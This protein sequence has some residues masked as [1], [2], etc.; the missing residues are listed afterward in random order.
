MP[1]VAVVGHTEWLTFARVARLP[2]PGEIVH[3]GDVW[4]EAAGGGGVAAVQLAR[5]AGGCD[6][7]TATGEAAAADLRSRGVTVHNAER[8][9]R[10]A[11]THLTADGERTITVLGERVVPHGADPLPWERLDGCDAVYYTGGDAAAAAHARRA[12]VMVAT[13]RAHDSLG[14]IELDALV[15]SAAD[16]DELGWAAGLQARHTFS[17]VGARGGHW[18]GGEWAAA[19]LPGPVVDA[20]GCGDTFAAGLTFALARGD[21]LPAALEF[22]AA[23]GTACLAGRGPYGGSLPPQ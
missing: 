11:F 18:E 6:F 12:R 17:T 22:A 20:Y 3:A 1:R 10:R 16:P 7:F 14:G 5:L 2:A 13:P 15:L 21:E 9:T 8:P 23:C 19:A 4:E